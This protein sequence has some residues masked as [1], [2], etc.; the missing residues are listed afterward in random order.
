MIVCGAAP[1]DARLPAALEACDRPG[2]LVLEA[3]SADT[4]ELVGHVRQQAPHVGILAVSNAS[5]SDGA[6]RLFRA[7]VRGFILASEPA[8]K[9]MM[10]IRAVAAG[11]A[12][13]S[14]VGFNRWPRGTIG[15]AAGPSD[16]PL[17]RLSDREI[18]VFR[19]LGDGLSVRE[20]A[21]K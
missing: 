20:I 9:L 19:M 15:L 21:Q 3:G 18:S 1:A 17:A 10:A 8:D 5:T 16:S 14:D 2:V 4:I 12:Y 11:G 7:G 13:L 6:S